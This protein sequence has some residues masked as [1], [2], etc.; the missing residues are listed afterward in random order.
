MFLD[1][2]I[3]RMQP[4]V[5]W[6]SYCVTQLPKVIKQHEIKLIQTEWYL[7]LLAHLDFI[8]HNWPHGTHV[9]FSLVYA[10]VCQ[11]HCVEG[12]LAGTCS[13][14]TICLSTFRKY[15][16]SSPWIKECM[17]TRNNPHLLV[18]SG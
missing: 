1:L 11:F 4:V 17:F 14:E 3:Q 5:P 18:L 12:I 6:V 15:M 2:F 10:V 7:L 8:I 13:N 9:Q 16:Y